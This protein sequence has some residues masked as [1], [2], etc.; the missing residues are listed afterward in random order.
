VERQL[1]AVEGERDVACA[2]DPAIER[3]R[4]MLMRVR[5][6][7]AASAASLARELFMR[8]LANRRQLASYLGLTPSPYDSGATTRC[9]RISKAGKASH[10]VFSS[11]LLGCGDRI[12]GKAHSPAGTRHVRRVGRRASVASCWWR[13]PA[14]SA[15]RC[16]AM[17]RPA[18]YPTG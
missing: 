1:R 4:E 16:G 14:S 8:S 2:Q 7:G 15:S 10:D 9:Q 17:S 12:S 11:S 13:S 3:K 5:G 6:V 18:S